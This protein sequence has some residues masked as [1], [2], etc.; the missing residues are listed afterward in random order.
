MQRFLFFL[1][2]SAC[3]LL[4][5]GL[6]AYMAGFVGGLLV[7]KSIDTSGASGILAAVVL[8]LLLIGLFAAQHSV[9][10]RPGFKRPWTRI[11]PQPIERSTY[12]LAS[13][14]VIGL[15]MWLWQGIDLVIWDISSPVGR[16]VAWGLFV[17]GW[18]A[19]P[20]V[21]LSINHFDL[22]GTRQV[23]LHLQGSDYQPLPF[24]VP[25]LYQF[26]RH[27]L[28]L[29]WMLAFWAIPTMTAGHLLFAVAMTGYMG[30]AAMAEER[31]LVAHFGR[32]YAE[33]QRQVP[34]FV[35]RLPS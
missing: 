2:G 31:D 17:L 26:V 19:V 3:Y 8:D 9:M 12:V 15:L 23:W 6:Y 13:C 30:L 18:L 33:Y 10:A 34:M 5:L 4:F 29:G 16:S 27:P 35:P 32:Q 11:V 7:P 14:I 28:Y 1:Y 21:S 22:F 24:K 25:F 20:L